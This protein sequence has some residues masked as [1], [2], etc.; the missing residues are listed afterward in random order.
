MYRVVASACQA[1][2]FLHIA[3]CKC[4]KGPPLVECLFHPRYENECFFSWTGPDP[5]SPVTCADDLF[6]YV[7]AFFL[8]ERVNW[9]KIRLSKLSI[10]NKEVVE[11]HPFF[12]PRV[13]SMLGN[14]RRI[15]GQM[16]DIILHSNHVET[17][18]ETRFQLSMWPR[19]E[20]SQNS[21]MRVAIPLSYIDS[22]VH[23]SSLNPQPF[24]QNIVGN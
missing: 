2:W 8:L 9:I 6:L 24:V 21:T 11:E 17:V 1:F 19:T 3:L 18:G 15:R 13:A 12:L 20:N 14:L 4:G 10:T 7:S 22:S 16:H 23:V 5:L